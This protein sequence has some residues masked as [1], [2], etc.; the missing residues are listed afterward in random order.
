MTGTAT[1][2]EP[3]SGLQH[4]SPARLNVMRT[5]LVVCALVIAIAELAIAADAST[6]GLL[7]DGAAVLLLAS[8]RWH[9]A[10]SGTQSPPQ[11]LSTACAVLALLPIMRLLSVTMPHKRVAE[12]G[13]YVLIGLPLLAVMIPLMGEQ[14]DLRKMLRLQGKYLSQGMIALGGIPLG[15]L[16]YAIAQPKPLPSGQLLNS[17]VVAF[18]I[19]TIFTGLMEEIL[20][21]GLLTDSA[22]RF[23]GPV[24]GTLGVTVLFAVFN[25]GGGLWFAIFALYYGLTFS[26]IVRRTGSLIGVTLAHGVLNTGLLVIWPQ[27]FG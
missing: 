7:F 24:L 18:I 4:I 10:P 16:G 26:L 1:A 8:N 27:V 15:L 19:L 17:P 2:A 12:M 6:V 3:R 5:Y 23:F 22:E 11:A 14:E 21:R 13:W 25:V 20:F 9:F